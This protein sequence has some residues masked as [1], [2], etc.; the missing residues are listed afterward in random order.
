M[1]SVHFRVM[2]LALLSRIENARVPYLSPGRKKM[3]GNPQSLVGNYSW[4]SRLRVPGRCLG[5]GHNEAVENRMPDK[6]SRA[7]D[8]EAPHQL[9]AMLFDR[10]NTHVQNAGNL[11]IGS[12]FHDELQNLSV[13]QGQM[14]WL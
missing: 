1:D 11:L 14:L 12:T 9:C 6:T 10:F 7:M 2:L 5:R 4:R 3:G 13:S 8:A